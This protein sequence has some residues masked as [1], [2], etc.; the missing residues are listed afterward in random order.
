MHIGN[1]HL[2]LVMRAKYSRYFTYKYFMMS[3][4][5]RKGLKT[6]LIGQQL[7]QDAGLD[8]HDLI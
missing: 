8:E 5:N 1:Q 4:T 7:K 2:L 3:S 6:D